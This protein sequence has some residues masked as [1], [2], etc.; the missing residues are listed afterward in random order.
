MPDGRGFVHG[1]APFP[2]VEFCSS[3]EFAD[4]KIPV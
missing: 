4:V 1:S 3:I 2:S